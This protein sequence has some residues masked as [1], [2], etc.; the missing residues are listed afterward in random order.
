M[1]GKSDAPALFAGFCLLRQD[2]YRCMQHENSVER[3]Y[4]AC[5]KMLAETLPV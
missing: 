4:A 2:R 1:D 5:V 3:V